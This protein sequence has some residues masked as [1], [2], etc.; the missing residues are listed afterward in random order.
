MERL[1]LEKK[2]RKNKQ[3]KE[4]ANGHHRSV[5]SITKGQ[6]YSI[7]FERAFP[8]RIA[9]DMGRKP[10]THIYAVKSEECDHRSLP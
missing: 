3:A 5:L 10:S 4:N 8:Q 7:K 1:I 9:K 2:I 6:F